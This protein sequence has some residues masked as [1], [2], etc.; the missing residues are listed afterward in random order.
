MDF[1]NFKDEELEKFLKVLKDESDSASYN[2][3]YNRTLLDKGRNKKNLIEIIIK[4]FR[5]V[6][7]TNKLNDN[8]L[9]VDLLKLKEE[10]VVVFEK[11]LKGVEENIKVLEK[12]KDFKEREIKIFKDMESGK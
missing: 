7:L 2:L 5:T 10:E 9:L 4:M 6:I 12:L 11:F 8:N 3:E 1:F